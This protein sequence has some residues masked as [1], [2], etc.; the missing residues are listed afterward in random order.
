MRSGSMGTL[1]RRWRKTKTHAF[2]IRIL[3]QLPAKKFPLELTDTV[4]RKINRNDG[5]GIKTQ[6]SILEKF[7][8]CNNYQ[9]RKNKRL[10]DDEL[11]NHE[12]SPQRNAGRPARS[13]FIFKCLDRPE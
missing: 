5:I 9:G 4:M 1:R 13:N 6:R 2:H 11:N 8:L 7:Y 12:Y 3:Q 10:R